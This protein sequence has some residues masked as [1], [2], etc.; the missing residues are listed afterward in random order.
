MVR[1]LD[2]AWKDQHEQWVD[3]IEGKQL[4]IREWKNKPTNW[5]NNLKGYIYWTKLIEEQDR[6]REM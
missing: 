2:I 5:K 3:N 6:M 4:N 1:S